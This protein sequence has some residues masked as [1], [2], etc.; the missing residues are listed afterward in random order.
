MS[1]SCTPAERPSDELSSR[2]HCFMTG[3]TPAPADAGKARDRI[4]LDV[5]HQYW[6]GD[7]Q[8]LSRDARRARCGQVLRTELSALDARPE[9]VPWTLWTWSSSAR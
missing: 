3:S 4:E 1:T 2:G 5:H 6:S 8:M 7:A 9:S